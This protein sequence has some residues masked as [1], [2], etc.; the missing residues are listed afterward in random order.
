MF[1]LYRLSSR[2]RV[3]PYNCRPQWVHLLSSSCVPVRPCSEFHSWLSARP[4]VN[5]VTAGKVLDSRI[6]KS[7]QWSTLWSE[8]ARPRP[9]RTRLSSCYF[10]ASATTLHVT[11]S[12]CTRTGWTTCC[13]WPRT[14]RV[15]RNDG[16][17]T[18]TV[19]SREWPGDPQT[20]GSSLPRCLVGTNRCHAFATS[21]HTG[22][23]ALSAMSHCGSRTIAL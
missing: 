23:Y 5:R 3:P 21:F 18:A 19:L 11:S 4:G 7:S 20:S 13:R 10:P 15:S 1:A 16:A 9:S 22:T 12:R 8:L 6:V 14:K 2:V 17:R